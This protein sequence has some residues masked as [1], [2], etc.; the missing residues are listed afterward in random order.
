VEL[1]KERFDY[2]NELKTSLEKANGKYKQFTHKIHFSNEDILNEN[3]GEMTEHKPCFIWI[4]N[5]CFDQKLTD[6]IFDK[7]HGEIHRD[8]IIC[9]SKNPEQKTG[10]VLKKQMIVP[11]SWCETSNVFIFGFE[12]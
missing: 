9:C 1:V 8:S 12:K 10:V 3:L 7:L 4:S 5:L 6:K 2:A 11:M